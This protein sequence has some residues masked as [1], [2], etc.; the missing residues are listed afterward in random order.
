MQYFVWVSIAFLLYRLYRADYL[1]IPSINSI[2]Y[3]VLSVILL[4]AANFINGTIWQQMLCV[5]NV[6]V[7]Y[8]DA[9]TSLGAS[10]FAK[11]IPGFVWTV[12]GSVGFIADK[13]PVSKLVLTSLSFTSQLIIIWIGLLWGGIAL[14]LIHDWWQLLIA[15]TIFILL[16][17]VILSPYVLRIIEWLGRIAFKADF[18]LPRVT[19]AKVIPVIP[20]YVL[21]WFVWNAAFHFFVLALYGNHVPLYTG[22]AFSLAAT[23]GILAIFA[24]GGVGV[25]EGMLFLFLSSIGM[26]S[27]EAVS[28][29]VASRVWFMVG[30]FIFFF[31]SLAW[32]Y[33]TP[34]QHVKKE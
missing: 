7:K 20:F 8:G 13:A 17:G 31:S 29:S 27:K 3:F 33:F 23:Y 26:P 30:E 2:P 16:G 25:R 10:I 22:M 18:T 21:L 6:K 11:Y 5:E 9:Y 28:I 1:H 12:M 15:L 32:M 14:I 4:Q 19:I 24:P 34:Q